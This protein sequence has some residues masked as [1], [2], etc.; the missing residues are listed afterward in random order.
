MNLSELLALLEIDEPADFD[1]VE[2]FAE[3]VEN[4]EEIPEEVLCELF[5][6]TDPDV[7]SELIDS[8]FSEIT[9]ILDEPEICET[10]D[11]VRYALM[12]LI[13]DDDDQSIY[14]FGEELARFH[15]WYCFD[16]HVRASIIGEENERSFCLRDAVTQKRLEKIEGEEYVFDF[17]DCL[18]YELDDFILDMASVSRERAEENGSDDL[19]DNGYVYDDEGSVL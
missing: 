13:E 1:Y 16:S 3:L 12:A 14:R 10:L 7:I 15:E 6:E 17:S 8:Y 18:D 9:Q 2:T 19:M 5:Q 4:D 11:S